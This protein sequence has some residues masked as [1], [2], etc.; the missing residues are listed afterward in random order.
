MA[1]NLAHLVSKL[2]EIPGTCCVLLV[3]AA[4]CSVNDV[5]RIDLMS[6]P[7]GVEQPG[8]SQARSQEVSSFPNEGILFATD[9]EPAGPEDTDRYYSG[10][11]GSALRVGLARTEYVGKPMSDTE[12]R[13]IAYEDRG[14]SNFPIA[15][16]DLEE[17]GFL[18]GALPYGFLTD[19]DDLGRVDPADERLAELINRRLEV[20]QSKDVFIYVHGYRLVFENPVIVS[21]QF[22]HFMNYDGIF[23]SFAWP[24]TPKRLAYFK[25]VE[26]AEISAHNFRLL[27]QFITD[28][29]NARR[30]HIIGYSAGTRVVLG[31]LHQLALLQTGSPQSKAG[32]RIGQVALVGSDYDPQRWAAAVADGLLQVPDALTIYVSPNDQ[33]LGLSRLVFGQERLGQVQNE[34]VPETISN[35]LIS[36]RKLFFVDVSAAAGFDFGDGH[37]YFQSSPWISGDMLA[38]LRHG[39]NPAERGLV[40][41]PGDLSWSF[42]SDYE[43]RLTEAV[44]SH[45]AR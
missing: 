15:V 17:F 1:R 31:A 30:V 13:E 4:G 21:A 36:H 26:T 7:A 23:M 2:H 41:E 39:L 12:L 33:A 10:E 35:W 14:K 11:R 45:S 20:S 18:E 16:T 9:R 6:I 42:P 22:W 44:R 5:Y 28:H 24:S 27:L 19:P 43:Q 8:S 29:T 3:L 38:I 34:A 25:D 37:S 32:E 40:R